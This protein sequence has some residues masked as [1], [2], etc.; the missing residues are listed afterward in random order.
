MKTDYA[1][2]LG[3]EILT[4]LQKRP[5]FY[6]LGELYKPKETCRNYKQQLQYLGDQLTPL[7]QTLP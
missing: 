3:N 7:I 6:D 1:N 4:F 5:K 2:E